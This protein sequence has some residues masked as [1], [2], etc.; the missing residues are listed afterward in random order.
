[1]GFW[2]FVKTDAEDNG[3]GYD[4]EHVIGKQE[5]QLR[6]TIVLRSGQTDDSIM[7]IADHTVSEYTIG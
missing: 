2:A 5:A 4:C 3:I 7:S 6:R 1:M